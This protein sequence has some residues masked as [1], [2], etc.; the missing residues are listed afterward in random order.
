MICDVTLAMCAD[1][2]LPAHPTSHG[3]RAFSC[4]WSLRRP[5]AWSVM[6]PPPINVHLGGKWRRSGSRGEMSDIYDCIMHVHYTPDSVLVLCDR[7]ARG[8]FRP[9]IRQLF[10]FLM[11][12]APIIQHPYSRHTCEWTF[13]ALVLIDNRQPPTAHWS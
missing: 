1:H 2:E 10:T 12:F 3:R 13:Q 7:G 8:T 4:N 6:L 5:L 9:C 11:W